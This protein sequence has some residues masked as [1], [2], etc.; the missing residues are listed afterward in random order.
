MSILLTSA[1]S[2]TRSLLDEPEGT[3]SSFW[4][5]T[6]LTT[7]LNEGCQDSQRRAEWKMATATLPVTTATQNFAAPDN[8]LR[9]HRVTFVPTA[10]SGNYQNTYTLEFRG[11]MEMDQVWGINQQWPASYP[12]YYTLFGQPG[13]G[14]LEI[15]TYP[16]SSQSGVLNVYYF[17]VITPATFTTTSDTTTFLDTPQ[18]YDG[19]IVNY[20]CYKALRKD[21]DSRWQEFKQDYE[22]QLVNLYDQ[23][24]TYQDQANFIS[25]GQQALPQWLTSSEGW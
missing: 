7:W 21:A 2:Q 22:S 25:T 4:S 10:N 23:S 13:T 1:I 3:T 18:G 15:I 12:L 8:A 14:S 20:A 16:V 9:I 24:R 5:D 11:F 19:M 17:P 6:E